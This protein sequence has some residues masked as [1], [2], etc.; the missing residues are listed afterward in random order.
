MAQCLRMPSWV[1]ILR[2][3]D[4]SY[5]TGVTSN[6]ER[7]LD[8]HDHGE[9]GYTASRKPFEFLWSDEFAHID[10]AIAFEKRVKGWSRAKKEALMR[11]EWTE[12]QRLSKSGATHRPSTGS[13]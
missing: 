13:G 8:Q 3:S 4:G 2:C 12:V 5:Y 9:I 7:R 1:Y 10:D 11:G 6:I